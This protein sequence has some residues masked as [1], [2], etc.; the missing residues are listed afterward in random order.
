MYAID[1]ENTETFSEMSDLSENLI[2]KKKKKKL[3][4]QIMKEKIMK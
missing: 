1:F 4:T 2:K 3:N